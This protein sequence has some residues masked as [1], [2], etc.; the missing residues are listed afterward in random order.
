MSGDYWLSSAA[1]IYDCVVPMPM[2]RKFIWAP[3]SLRT[4]FEP[5]L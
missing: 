4:R 2:S 5:S 1:L 3:V